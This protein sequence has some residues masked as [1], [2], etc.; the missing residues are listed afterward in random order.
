MPIRRSLAALALVAALAAPAAAAGLQAPPPGAPITADTFKGHAV[1]LEKGVKKT[2]AMTMKSMGQTMTRT[3]TV[4]VL[5]VKGGK[6]T[7]RSSGMG[8]TLTTTVPIADAAV[9]GSEADR[10]GVKMVSGGHED[11]TVPA[12]TYK[13]AV[14][15][16]ATTK[17]GAKVT[18]WIDGKVGVVK[19]RS[20]V[21]IG[22]GTATSTM[23]L[24]SYS[25]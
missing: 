5:D 22:G 9:G 11:V 8:Q 20:E 15:I 23:E 19:S 2:F 13:R 12:G 14:K 6:A 3:M 4:E 16:V 21:K 17:D 24:T 1:G 25:K 18:T 7:M 10:A